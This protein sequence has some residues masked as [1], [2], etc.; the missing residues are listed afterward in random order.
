M[1]AQLNDGGQLS[2][3]LPGKADRFGGRLIHD[4]HAESLGLHAVGTSRAHSAANGPA[5]I[6]C[7]YERETLAGTAGLTN[8]APLNRG[9]RPMTL[10]HVRRALGRDPAPAS[11]SV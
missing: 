11:L 5:A 1:S 7:G 8:T 10:D 9:S 2:P 3:V 6:A 4:E